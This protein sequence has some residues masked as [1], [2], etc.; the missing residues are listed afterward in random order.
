M[1]RNYRNAILLAIALISLAMHFKHFSKELVSIHVWRQTQTQSTIINFYEGD[2]N[3]FSPVRN[4]R[5]SGD[6]IYRMEFP[7]MQWLVACTYKIFGNHLIITRI[8]MFVIGLFSI[9]GIY[10]LLSAL[11]KNDP[12]ALIGAWAFNF[13]PSFFYYTINPLPDN[14]A[15]CCAIWGLALFF[16]WVRS[17][18]LSSLL[19]SGLFLCIGALCK[20]PFILYFM[21][22]FTWMAMEWFNKGIS[23]SLVIKKLLFSLFLVPPLVW[24][25]IVVPKWDTKGIITGLS[26]NEVPWATVLEYLRFNVISTLPE[27][28]LNYGS[29]L[30]FL[31]G[32]WF[33][34]RN[35]AFKNAAFPLLAVL[36]LSVIGY[37][38]YEVNMIANVH[39][40]YLFP[41]LPLLFMLVSYGAYN[42][43]KQPNKFVRYLAIMLLLILPLTAYLRMQ[44]RWDVDS[45]G[46]NKDLLTYKQELRNAVP[47]DALCV[48]GSD[49][50]HYIYF[51]YVDK[52]GWGFDQDKLDA[53]ALRKMIG[54]GAGYLYS[55][56]RTVDGNAAIA[57]CLDH[58]ILEKGSVRV[59]KLR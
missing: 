30:F 15:L 12:L 53:V 16:I 38:L 21:V 29:L 40:Y 17:M 19:F 59:Y 18:K 20:L 47:K 42:M 27:L 44:V 43:L 3:I 6:G 11:F 31:A 55:D 1:K 51:Y 24:Y 45:P 34:A 33:L 58:L 13:S 54:E 22:P 14:L 25:A 9:A 56:S 10:K 7:L 41:F 49:E 48:V 36:G 2:M 8:W 32:F 35:K 5:G 57:S 23:R 26:G 28:L 39:D 37:F 4:E 52:K 46:F 50:S